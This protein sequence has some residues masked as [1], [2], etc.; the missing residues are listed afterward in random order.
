MEENSMRK[1]EIDKDAVVASRAVVRGDVTVG[2]DSSIWYNAVVRGD[3]QSIAI[4]EGTNI[5]DGAILHVDREYPLCIGDKVT[6]GHGAILHG[7][8]VEDYA[9]IGMGAIVMNGAVVGKGSIVAAGALV[10][11]NTVI[12]AGSLAM[13]NP[14]KIRREL[15]TEEI[16]ASIQNAENYIRESKEMEQ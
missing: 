9:L 13:G 12:P 11:Q 8:T 4:G 16:Q 10:P 15:R 2:K 5:Q 7:C 1:P 14:A 3:V 6:V